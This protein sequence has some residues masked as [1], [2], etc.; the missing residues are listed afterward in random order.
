M[1]FPNGH[2]ERSVCLSLCVCVSLVV[3][4]SLPR[5]F[6]NSCLGGKKR[7]LPESFDPFDILSI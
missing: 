2:S 6:L 4:I 7:R 5:Y 1:I 3:L